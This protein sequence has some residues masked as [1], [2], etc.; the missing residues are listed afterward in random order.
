MVLNVYD[1]ATIYEH[2]IRLFM[3]PLCVCQDIGAN[4]E[5]SS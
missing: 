5:F 2:S 4:N 3:V 1:I